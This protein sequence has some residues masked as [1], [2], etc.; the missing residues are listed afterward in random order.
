MKKITT[1]FLASVMFAG[2]VMTAS[3]APL[4]SSV[5][6]AA[7]P[8]NYRKKFRTPTEP[9]AG[10][11]AFIRVDEEDGE[12]LDVQKG[13]KFRVLKIEIEGN[14]VFTDEE[15]APLYRHLTE[16]KITLG[17]LKS[18]ARDITKKYREKGYILSK[19]IVP[20]QRI[21]K[22]SSKAI[23]RVIEGSVEDITIN[24]I[25]FSLT[26]QIEKYGER[27]K[28]SKPLNNKDLERYLLLMNDLPGV[29]AKAVF[30]KGRSVGTSQMIVNVE[31]DR[32]DASVAAH[33]YSSDYLGREHLEATVG[34]NS[35]F[36]LNERTQL[37]AA[38]A[39]DDNEFY[40][41]GAVHEAQVGATGLKLKIFGDYAASEPGEDLEILNVEG[42]TYSGGV[43]LEYPIIRSRRQNLFA[44]ASFEALHSSVELLG[45]EAYED[46]LRVGR[47]QLYYDLIDRLKGISSVTG[48]LSQGFDILGASDAGVDVS[49]GN[50]ADGEFTKLELKLARLQKIYGPFSA[51]VAGEGQYSFNPLLVAEEFGVGGTEF[52]RGYDPAELVGDHGVAATA[53]LRFSGVTSWGFF[54]SYQ[55]YGFYDIGKVWDEDPTVGEPATEAMASVGGGMRFNLDTFLEGFSGDV[56]IA[57]PLTRD[58]ASEDDKDPRF[59]FSVRQRF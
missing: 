54:P 58:V 56:M 51:Y 57:Q 49:R 39:P 15:L 36:G 30:A 4:P 41:V 55:L 1:A 24:G 52:G 26:K 25:G 19:A 22:Q 53:E 8:G 20:S 6:S 59:F 13:V 14:T 46:E 42:K 47:L 11:K 23:I 7:D 28:R 32:F 18:A 37:K 50:G 12:I 44:S 10:G 40:Y 9:K 2:T 21:K 43:K 5:P 35:L 34:V 31:R 33:N 17:D 45:V 38:I 27:I 3:A 48:R 16:G 29:T